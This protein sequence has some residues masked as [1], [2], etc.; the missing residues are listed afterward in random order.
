MIDCHARQEVIRAIEAFLDREIMAFEFDDRLQAIETPDETIHWVIYE[1]W[2]HYDD[3]TDHFECLERRDWKYLQRL[4]LLLASDHEIQLQKVGYQWGVSSA[5]FLTLG[6]V[7]MTWFYAG[8]WTAIPLSLLLS[9]FIAWWIIL[10]GNQS[11][12]REAVDIPELYP[13]HSISELRA[14]RMEIPSFRRMV[15]PNRTRVKTRFLRRA[16]AVVLW[17]FHSPVILVMLV[18]QS[19]L[20]RAVVL[21]KP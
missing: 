20:H 12:V 9:S 15:F 13:F 5:A 18:M 3:C 16:L 8:P 21:A 11:S 17:I 6:C 7:V 10:S 1:L 19:F 2:K 14:V 4:K